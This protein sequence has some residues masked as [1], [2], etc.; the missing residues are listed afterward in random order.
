MRCNIA[1]LKQERTT[2]GPFREQFSRGLLTPVSHSS[3]KAVAIPMLKAFSAL[4]KTKQNGQKDDLHALI[5]RLTK[6][7]T[8]LLSR[9]SIWRLSLR[10]DE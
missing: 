8:V 7:T 10:S 9:A 6:P 5:A 2:L 1:R 4:D 3:G